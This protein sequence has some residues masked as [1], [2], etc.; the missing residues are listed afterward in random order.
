[1]TEAGKTTEP[2]PIEP[3]GSTW[4][5]WAVVVIV[6]EIALVVSVLLLAVIRV[7]ST[8]TYIGAFAV[9][10]LAG[11]RVGGVRGVGQWALAAI[12]IFGVA[13]ALLYIAILAVVS[14][15]TGP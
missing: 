15:I 6:G 13:V 1:M 12:L 5:K 7:E 11:G 10:T 9:A 8:L 14:Q 4:A 2:E 3:G